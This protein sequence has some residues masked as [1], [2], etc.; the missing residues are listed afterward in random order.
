MFPQFIGGN[1]SASKY[2]ENTTHAWAGQFGKMYG[3]RFLNSQLVQF[4]NFLCSGVS[5]EFVMLKAPYR[6]IVA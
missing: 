3:L 4:S 1:R 5:I 6:E 2:D